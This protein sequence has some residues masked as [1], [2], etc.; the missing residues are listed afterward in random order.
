MNSTRFA[1]LPPETTELIISSLPDSDLLSICQN[2]IF[3][4]LCDW[5]FWRRRTGE[6]FEVPTWYFDLGLSRQ[7]SGAYRYLEVK[8]QFR[9]SLED[10]ATISPD[11]LV[12]GIY[13]PHQL[14][15]N[16]IYSRDFNLIRQLY[17]ILSKED[18]KMVR[19]VIKNIYSDFKLKHVYF[20][21]DL[22]PVIN[23][24]LQLSSRT[25]FIPSPQEPIDQI[26]QGDWPAVTQNIRFTPD[27]DY[28]ERVLIYL[29]Y[30]QKTGAF[31]IVQ[32]YISEFNKNLSN[33]KQKIFRL[34]RA[35]AQTG[36]YDQFS[37]ILNFIEFNQE[38][39]EYFNRLP[40]IDDSHLIAGDLHTENLDGV[41]YN[42]LYDAYI[43]ANQDIIL[44]FKN[45][46]FAFSTNKPIDFNLIGPDYGG[47]SF[48]QLASLEQIGYPKHNEIYSLDAGRNVGLSNPVSVYRV[49]NGIEISK[50]EDIIR[51]ISLGVEVMGL[52]FTKYP[53]LINVELMV[54]YLPDEN[55]DL[56]DYILKQISTLPGFEQALEQR[57][58]NYGIDEDT[59]SGRIIRSYLPKI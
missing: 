2:E 14:F 8:T 9:F 31:Q 58:R 37:W 28:I 24:L 53:Q 45:W 7:I 52:L 47:I 56:L 16:T 35:S 54:K 17:P 3:S 15:L 22:I 49:I 4:N 10:L 6:L 41:V 19:Q 1:Q 29:I 26:D 18:P 39:V 11:G 30:T 13:E 43:G 21:W 5:N 55:V 34:L 42:P 50:K 25:D 40:P 32:N 38:E 59:I 51:S 57:I 20:N 36:N 12:S 27:Q 48:E 44:I 23:L 33:R 46:G